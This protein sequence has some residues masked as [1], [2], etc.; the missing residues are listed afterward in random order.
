MIANDEQLE[1]VREQVARLESAVRSLS[2]SVRPKSEAMFQVMLEGPA[3][4]LEALRREI[5]AYTGSAGEA[6]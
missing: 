2:E 3:D 6:R 1:I 4:H 5:E